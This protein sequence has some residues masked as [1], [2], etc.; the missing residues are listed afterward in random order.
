MRRMDIQR[1]VESHHRSIFPDVNRD[2]PFLWDEPPALQTRRNNSYNSRFFE[3]LNPRIR[4]IE[5]TRMIRRENIRSEELPTVQIE[6]NVKKVCKFC[7]ENNIPK[8]RKSVSVDEPLKKINWE[9]IFDNQ[10]KEK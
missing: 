6:K 5:R 7:G 1:A 4:I 2:D 3:N 9:L 8:T 10:C